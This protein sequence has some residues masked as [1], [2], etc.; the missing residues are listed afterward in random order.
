MIAPKVEKFMLVPDET[1]AQPYLSIK[2]NS[3]AKWHPT[4]SHQG[5]G[6]SNMSAAKA[7]K[8]Q[9]EQD[10]TCKNFCQQIVVRWIASFYCCCWFHGKNKSSE[11]NTSKAKVKG[12]MPKVGWLKKSW[13]SLKEGVRQVRE[14]NIL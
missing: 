4:K 8:W 9:K 10:Q 12:V 7:S 3:V 1:V 2:V 14:A 13:L 6:S 11:E 5:Y